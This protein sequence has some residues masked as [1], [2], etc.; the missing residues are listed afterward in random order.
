MC[1]TVAFIPVG[2]CRFVAKCLVSTEAGEIF[3]VTIVVDICLF[4]GSVPPAVCMTWCVQ[5]A[6]G[7]P[8]K[9][10]ADYQIP[11]KPHTDK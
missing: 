7:Q 4:V 2:S 8:V 6:K 10:K 1:G 5:G 11:P 9:V 3:K